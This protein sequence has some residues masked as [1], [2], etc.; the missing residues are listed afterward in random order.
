M[1]SVAYVP[2][3][4]IFILT[5][6]IRKYQAWLTAS[7]KSMAYLVLILRLHEYNC[8]SW[9]FFKEINVAIYV[10]F[11]KFSSGCW[12]KYYLSRACSQY[13]LCVKIGMKNVQYISETICWFQIIWNCGFETA[14]VKRKLY[15]PITQG[16]C[17]GSHS[18][19]E[20]AVCIVL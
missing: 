1:T 2:R 5:C 19:G 4:Q 15:I 9:S 20:W 17:L 10:D 11:A 7:S 16:R 14:M 3:V 6:H 12:V 13:F 8:I 18:Y